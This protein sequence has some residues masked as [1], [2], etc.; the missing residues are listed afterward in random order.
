MIR[1]QLSQCRDWVADSTMSADVAFDGVATDSRTAP[2][3]SLFIALRGEK[4]DAHAFLAEVAARGVAAIVAEAGSAVQHLA[5]LTVPLLLVPD[6]RRALGEIAL[7]W[8]RQFTMPVIGVTG[9]N[10]KT[11]VKEMIAAILVAGVGAEHAMATRGNFNNDIGLP[12]T[13]L[14]L[15]TATR[16]AVIEIGMNHPGEIAQLA[17]LAQPTVALVNNAQRE[18]QEFMATVEA[19]AQ[20]NGAVITSLAADGVAVFPADEVFTPLWRELAAARG[21][22]QVLAFGFSADADVRCTHVANAFGSDMTVVAGADCFTVRLAAAGLHNVRNA[23][24]AIACTRA[25]GIPVAAIV[26]G[27]EAFAPVA[28]RLQRRQAASGTQ[29]I[30]DTYNANPDSVRAAIEVLAQAGAPRVL[31]LGDM[32]EVGDAGAAFHAEIGAY[33]RACGIDHLLTLGSLASASTEAFGAQATHFNDINA[34]QAAAV[35]LATPA[36][37]VLVKGSRFMQ[38]ERVVNHLA[39]PFSAQQLQ[40]SH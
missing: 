11:T 36:A 37:T 6:S 15:N 20:E 23:L 40:D 25:I 7:G 26:R 3:G 21:Q 28:G 13:L 24:A 9:S 31:V 30:D 2:A 32:G 18:H 33:A 16:A 29:V 27:L 19:V 22:R 38:M 10:G 4:F 17:A 39:Q 35:A 12:L 8:R 1:A 5:G 14:R 34:L